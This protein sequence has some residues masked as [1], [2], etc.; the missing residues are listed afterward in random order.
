MRTL[1]SALMVGG[2]VLGLGVGAA[3]IGG[4]HF[5]SLPW[6]VSIGLA[7]L[8]LLASGGLLGVGAVC[9][10]LAARDERHQLLSEYTDVDQRND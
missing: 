4:S 6:I 9:H 7:K 1:G 2:L 3:I 10:R 5:I 8:T